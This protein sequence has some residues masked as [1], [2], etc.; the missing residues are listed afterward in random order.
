LFAFA[1]GAQIY[2]APIISNGRIYT[3]STDST[4]YAFSLAAPPPTATAVPG[5]MSAYY[6]ME[7]ASWN[8]TAAEVLD[9]S[10][11]GLNGR[12][13]GGAQTAN[14]S[15]A[16]AGDPGSCRYAT[17]FNGST[18]YLDLGAPSLSLTNGLTVM[19]WVRWG[20]APSTGNNWANIVSNNSGTASDTGQFWLQH[21]QFNA[22]F[23][24]A[25]Q[26]TSNRNWV[27]STIAPVQGQWQ[28]VAGVYNGSTLTIYVNGV[29]NGSVSLTGTI[30]A[31][32]SGYHLT[33]GRWAFNSETFRSFSG[34]VDE[35][36]VYPRAL[37]AAELSAAMSAT[38]PCLIP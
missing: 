1:T 24:F 2:G 9:G 11:N 4:V 35:V 31:P 7:S 32:S 6:A 38:H 22:S 36:R 13:V 5:G 30:V 8:G 21:S 15:P 18:S 19:A 23:E 20:I 27:Q 16:I 17:G 10:G 33:I 34:D 28:H 12:S 3:G 37:S 14:V 29:A 26:T 25:A